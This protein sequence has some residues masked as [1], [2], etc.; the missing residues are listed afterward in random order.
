MNADQAQEVS[1]CKSCLEAVAETLDTIVV[2]QHSVVVSEHCQSEITGDN[3]EHETLTSSQSDDTCDEIHL[4]EYEGQVNV[5]DGNDFQFAI[6]CPAVHITSQ[7]TMLQDCFVNSID[8]DAIWSDQDSEGETDTVEARALMQTTGSFDTTYS[9]Q[10]TSGYSRPM[11][12]FCQ[13]IKPSKEFPIG[14]ELKH[15]SRDDVTRISKID[16]NSPF[17]KAKCLQAGDHLIAINGQSVRTMNIKKITE[18]IQSI[19]GL[20][21]I[22]VRNEKGDS[23]TVLNSVPKQNADT[24]VGLAVRNDWRNGAKL[25]VSKIRED[26]PFLSSLLNVGQQI[27]MINDVPCGNLRAADAAALIRQSHNG[28]CSDSN[29]PSSLTILS[30]IKFRKSLIDVATVISCEN[31]EA[32]RNRFFVAKIIAKRHPNLFKKLKSIVNIHKEF[33]NHTK[34]HFALN[35]NN[36]NQ[37]TRIIA[38]ADSF[39]NNMSQRRISNI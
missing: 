31:K 8:A 6:L 25:C 38:I 2:S 33:H 34:A 16:P 27:L 20:I 12:I 32:K 3:D 26:S 18:L 35:N 15:D 22:T 14:L 5:V 10:D 23:N 21:S 9:L 19:V 28:T 17:A 39:T 7:D 30:T 11:F 24:K 36:N 29:I 1:E 13:I 37:S 4:K